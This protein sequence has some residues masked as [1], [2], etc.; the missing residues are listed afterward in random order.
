MTYSIVAK[1]PK[2]GNFGIGV[3]SHWF[4]SGIVCWAKAGVG[5]VATQA[6]ALI[7]HGPLGLENMRAGESAFTSLENRLNSDET[8]EIRQVAMLDYEGNVAVHTGSQTI[9]E[10]GHIVGDGFSCQA[11]MMWNGSVWEGMYDDFSKSEGDL[12][13]RLLSSLFA[14]QSKGGDIRGKQ[15]S[16]I[17]IVSSEPKEKPWEETI[18][19]LRV[20]D[21][22]NPLSELE[23]L[24]DLHDQYASFETANLDS[25]E[26][27]KIPELAFWKSIELANSG[28]ESEARDLFNFAFDQDDCWRELLIRC[29]N[30]DLLGIT[31]GTVEIL[32]I[33]H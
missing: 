22:S 21:H 32:L 13:R 9:P 7:D 11:N 25:Y 26:H 20:D 27:V 17:L 4:A 3:Q 12:S 6:M 5:A 31:K 24:L 18:V 8:P 14:A 15:S 2:T 33:D 28:Q 10:S 23:R 1:C 16:R 29:S 19:D 30:K